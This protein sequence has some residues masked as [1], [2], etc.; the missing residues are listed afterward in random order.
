MIFG[1]DRECTGT[2]INIDAED[3]IIKMDRNE[4][5]KILPLKHLAKISTVTE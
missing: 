1:D 5:L 3:G 2:L 4:Q